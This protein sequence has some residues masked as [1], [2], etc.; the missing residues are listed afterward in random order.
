MRLA[1]EGGRFIRR[2]V[3]TAERD[4]V[5]YELLSEPELRTFMP[6][7]HI[8]PK[9]NGVYIEKNAGYVNIRELVDAH[10]K[11]ASSA[12]CDIQDDII[13][14]IT[15]AGD[16]DKYYHLE[17][18]SGRVYYSKKVLLATGAFTFCRNLLPP[19]IVPDIILQPICVIKVS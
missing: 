9:E 14:V 8:L 1:R 7:F 4:G 3:G 6:Y 15:P 19:D 2:S 10:R 5:P 11:L 16:K 13:K 12:G 18:D 17:T